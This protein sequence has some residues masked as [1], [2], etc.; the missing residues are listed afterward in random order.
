MG[1]ASPFN[2]LLIYFMSL[3]SCKGTLI[4]GTTVDRAVPYGLS[5]T[6]CAFSLYNKPAFKQG[7]GIV[8]S[9]RSL[10]MH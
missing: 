3:Y 6:K 9:I 7:C 1:L 5:P 2:D 10:V 4:P 8:D